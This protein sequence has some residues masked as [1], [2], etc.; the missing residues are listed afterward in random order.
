MAENTVAV[1]GREGR[2][3]WEKGIPWSFDNDALYEFFKGCGAI[4]E[5]YVLLSILRC[6]W[7]GDPKQENQS[8]S[9]IWFCAFWGQ[10]WH[11][12]MPCNGWNRSEACFVVTCRNAKA[13]PWRSPFRTRKERLLPNRSTTTRTRW[14]WTVWAGTP[15]RRVCL[16]ICR[17]TVSWKTAG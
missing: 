6:E 15:L 3:E 13:V 12:C 2:R 14:L 4:S 16:S 7:I 9:W 17:S 10:G 11:G 8:L 5:C 1:F